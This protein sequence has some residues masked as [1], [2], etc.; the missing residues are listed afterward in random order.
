MRTFDSAV[1]LPL[2]DLDLVEIHRV[3]VVD[4]GPKEASQ[5][6]DVAV[7]AHQLG[8]ARLPERCRRELRETVVD[9]RLPGDELERAA[10]AALLPDRAGARIEGGVL[11]VGG[12]GR[13]LDAP[14]HPVSKRYLDQVPAPTSSFQLTL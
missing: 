5:I 9:H 7:A 13:D 14:L 6:A 12:H 3:V 10:A 11:T 8:A 1:G 4:G 2:G